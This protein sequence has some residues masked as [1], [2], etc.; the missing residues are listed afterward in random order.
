MFKKMKRRLAKKKR[1]DLIRRICG[2]TG[3]IKLSMYSMDIKQLKKELKRCRKEK[4]K[5]G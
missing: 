1:A 3:I 4:R 2:V 5:K